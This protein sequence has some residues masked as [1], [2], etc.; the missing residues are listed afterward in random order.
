VPSSPKPAAGTSLADIW[1]AW[2]TLNDADGVVPYMDYSTPTFY[3]TLTAA[4]QKVG[5]GKDSPMGGAR[6][7]RTSCVR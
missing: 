3:D 2:K 1:N 6:K 5:A 4:I 7:N